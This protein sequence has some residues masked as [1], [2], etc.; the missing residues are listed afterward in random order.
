MK[1]TCVQIR[2]F[3]T[4]LLCELYDFAVDFDVIFVGDLELKILS[5][6]FT[7]IPQNINWRC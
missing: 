3:A 1:A 4:P 2:R 5:F 6:F 7:S